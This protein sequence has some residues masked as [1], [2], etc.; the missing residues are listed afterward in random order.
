MAIVLKSDSVFLSD[1]AFNVLAVDTIGYTQQKT[2]DHQINRLYEISHL[3]SQKQ[4]ITIIYLIGFITALNLTFPLDT[5]SYALLISSNGY[6]SVIT[7][8]FPFNNIV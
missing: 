5:L 7:L 3:I 6:I 1:I 4:I 2:C 8:T